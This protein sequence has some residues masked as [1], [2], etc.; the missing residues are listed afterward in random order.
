VRVRLLEHE[1]GLTWVVEEALERASHALR[2]DA[3]RVWLIDPVDDGG[4]AVDRALA[5]GSPAGVIRLLDRHGRDCDALA[6]RLGVPLL[7]LP[8]AIPGS[9][10]EVI[11]VLDVPGWHERALWWPERRALVVAEVVGT[12]PH[13]T[14]GD[15]RPAGIHPLL[16]LRPPGAL[17]SYQPEHLLPGHGAPIHG[18]GAARALHDAYANSRRDLPRLL[19]ALP[20]LLGASRGRWG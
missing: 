3:G 7:S 10:L 18:P 2:D 6:A 20:A 1:L 12:T 5:L 14:L 11:R 8:D 13:T 17:R 16:R 9:P 4:S 15:S 19:L